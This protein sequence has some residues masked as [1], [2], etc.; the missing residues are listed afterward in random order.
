M[1]LIELIVVLVL[2]GV[3]MYLVNTYI[4]MSAGM[5]RLL[6]IA[7]LV[8]VVF[9]LLKVLGLFDSLSTVTV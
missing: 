9:W 3:V 6:N 2:I 4:P 7:V 5:K 1:P 8:V